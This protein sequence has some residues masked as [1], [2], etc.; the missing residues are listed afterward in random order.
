MLSERSLGAPRSSLRATWLRLASRADSCIHSD[1]SGCTTSALWPLQSLK[2][3]EAGDTYYAHDGPLFKW[4]EMPCAIVQARRTARSSQRV[5]S[6]LGCNTL[7]A[8]TLPD[9][10]TALV[11]PSSTKSL[12]LGGEHG[13]KRRLHLQ[14]LLL[15][16]CM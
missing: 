9:G 8:V 12:F 2:V 14:T 3:E 6:P 11:R 7:L 16:I 5:T 15:Q 10:R 13:T 4:A 1:S